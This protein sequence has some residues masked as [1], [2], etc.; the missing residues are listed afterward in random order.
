MIWIVIQCLNLKCY[1]TVESNWL[2][3]VVYLENVCLENINWIDLLWHV[4]HVQ[5]LLVQ[6]TNC[7]CLLHHIVHIITLFTWWYCSH[8]DIVRI[9]MI[10]TSVILIEINSEAQANSKLTRS[11]PFQSMNSFNDLLIGSEHSDLELSFVDIKFDW[12]GPLCH[13]MSRWSVSLSLWLS[14]V[15][16]N[17][18][19]IFIFYEWNQVFYWWNGK[20]FVK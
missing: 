9:M 16:L 15:T 8:D 1:F 17:Q 4:E 7:P 11:I 6:K 14:I 2:F 3:Q 18:E 10:I 19:N 5:Y 20:K 12:L 13:W